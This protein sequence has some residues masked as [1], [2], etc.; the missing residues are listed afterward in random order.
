MDVM[1]ATTAELGSNPDSTVKFV[2]NGINLFQEAKLPGT[3][4]VNVDAYMEPF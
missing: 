3:D 1:S 4:V 2:T